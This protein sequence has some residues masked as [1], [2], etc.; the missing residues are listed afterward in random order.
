MQCLLD[1]FCGLL[2]LCNCWEKEDPISQLP[3]PLQVKLHPKWDIHWCEF[4]ANLCEFTPMNRLQTSPVLPL[5]LLGAVLAW[6]M[7]LGPDFYSMM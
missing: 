1:G 7:R 5:F 3:P 2:P 4:R 6:W